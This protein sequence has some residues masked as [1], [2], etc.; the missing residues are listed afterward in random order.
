MTWIL[1]LSLNNDMH[2]NS[3]NK[4]HQSNVNESGELH[5]DISSGLSDVNG[6]FACVIWERYWGRGVNWVWSW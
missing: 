1:T 6:K 2:G 5:D 3:L 4:Q